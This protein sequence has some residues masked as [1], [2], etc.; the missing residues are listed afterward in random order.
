MVKNTAGIQAADNSMGR[1]SLLVFKL[2]AIGNKERLR[3]YKPKKLLTTTMD[4]LQRQR[5]CR[6]MDN[7][8]LLIP[9]VAAVLTLLAAMSSAQVSNW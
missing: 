4:E 5:H 8:Q 7:M 3:S 9:L 2:Q 1:K 6:N